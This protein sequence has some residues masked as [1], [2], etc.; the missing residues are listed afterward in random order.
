VIVI[1]TEA[2][3]DSTTRRTTYKRLERTRRWVAFIRSNL[4]EP[5]KL[6]VGRLQFVIPG[7]LKMRNLL[8]ISGLCLLITGTALSQK[9]DRERDGLKGSVKMVRVQQATISNEDGKQT[10]SPLL[11]THVVTYD[12]SGNRTELALYD[13]SGNLS[14]RIAYQYDPETKR[15]S[16][17]ITYN[18][19]NAM[20]RKVD[21][22]Y[23][24]TGSKVSST[25]QDFNED[26]T[27]FRKTELNFGPLGEL[28]EVAEYQG[29]GS[30]IKKGSWSIEDAEVEN[31]RS[32]RIR[33]PEDLDRIVGFG[34]TAGEYFDVDSHGNW[35]R[36]MTGSTTRTYSS[37]RKAKTTE[38]ANRE[39]TYY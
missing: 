22:K 27:L 6:N 2:P 11:L 23:G 19:Q 24:S 36:G 7:D 12:Q 28:I 14:R 39:F 3:R 35:T 38:W 8:L 17:L 4:G 37:G 34:Q 29:D 32:T 30:L 16:G 21:D 26:G 18:S 25:I 20:V 31:D 9:T 13:Q 5:L 1:E 33:P 10:E 15:K